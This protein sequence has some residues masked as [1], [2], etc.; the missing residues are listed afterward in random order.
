MPPQKKRKPISTKRISDKL[1]RE[2]DT[3]RAVI[4]TDAYAM[5][6]GEWASLYEDE[7][8]DIHPE[9]QR[10]YRWTNFQKSRFIESILLG[11]PIPPIFVAQTERG[12]WDVVDGLQRLSTLFQFMGI[13]QDEK[14]E[15]LPP[16][17][18]EGTQYLP[19]L[20]SKMWNDPNKPRKSLSSSQRL[21]FKR[22]KLDV[23][24]ILRESE[25]KAKYELFQRLNT[26]GTQLS[27][28]EVRNCII[29]MLDRSFFE[30]LKKISS[31]ENFQDCVS[32]TD[33][34]I[35][36]QYDMELALRFI[37]FRKL[38]EEK[39]SKIRDLGQFLT[40]QMVELINNSK[41][42]WESEIS[43]FKKTFRNLK[44]LYGSDIFRRYDKT[45]KQHTGGFL[46]SAF[47]VIAMGIGYYEEDLIVSKAELRK[48][49]RNLWEDK[50]FKRW[51]GSGISASS[52]IPKLVPL[53]R[54]IFKL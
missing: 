30:S 4:K 8:L 46:I 23:S 25:E 44:E 5:S 32:L 33:K 7:E 1:Q 43:V 15:T 20:E 31:D 34:A 54:K 37:V 18:L 27:D 39:L 9:F 24:I 51:S 3:A 26:G 22:T 47:E 29:V 45:K 14:A 10:F 28:Q 21:F 38:E 12:T 53:G 13:L 16:L 11:I 35:L 50:V 2:I 17:I 49:V 40:G 48:K 6:I 19:S 41:F 36:E 52:R 42:S